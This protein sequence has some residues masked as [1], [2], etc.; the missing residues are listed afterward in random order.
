MCGSEG[1]G[2][3]SRGRARL[4]ERAA[5]GRALVG[6]ASPSGPPLLLLKNLQPRAEKPKT[7]AAVGRARLAERAVF[8]CRDGPT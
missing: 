7:R 5:G 8:G 3:E 6:P 4:A 2:C 1:A